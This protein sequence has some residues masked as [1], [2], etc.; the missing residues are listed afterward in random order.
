MEQ[1]NQEQK[2]DGM[3]IVYP[4]KSFCVLPFGSDSQETW[5][6]VDGK[7]EE[8]TAELHVKNDGTIRFSPLCE[9]CGITFPQT[10]NVPKTLVLEL[11]ACNTETIEP[12]L[13]YLKKQSDSL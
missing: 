9:E 10:L 1:I 5:L 3:L 2:T 7:C 4:G 8:K 6:L 12:G 13:Y 11:Y